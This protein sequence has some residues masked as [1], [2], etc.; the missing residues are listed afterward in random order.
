MASQDAELS[1]TISDLLETYIATFN[2]QDLPGAASY[3]DEPAF[4]ISASGAKL[5]PARK[6]YVSVF[7]ETVQRLK[8]SGWDHSEFIGE[9][10][11]NVMQDD[12]EGA[13]VMA[14][15]PC[16]RLRKDGSS[17]EEFTASYTLR[18]GGDRGWLI[19]GIHHSPFPK[20]R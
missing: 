10:G 13:L 2:R 14:S 12:S 9:K 11:I 7:T 3:Y 6:D 19:V 8:D 20:D 16:Q 1:K 18:R 4:I 15:C 5:M 17:V